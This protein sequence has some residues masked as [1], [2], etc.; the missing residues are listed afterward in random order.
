[1][2]TLARIGLTTF[3]PTTISCARTR[4]GARHKIANKKDAIDLRHILFSWT[5]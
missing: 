2:A 4:E 1:L 5:M 3:T